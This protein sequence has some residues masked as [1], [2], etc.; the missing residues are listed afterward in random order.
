MNEIRDKIWYFLV[1]SKTNEVFSNLV[2]KK[3]QKLDLITNI[4]LVFTTSSSI[5][6]WTFWKELPILWA[7]IIGLS[8]LMTIVKPYFLF[9]KYIKTFNEK[10]IQWQ[11]LSLS[12]EEL[13]FQ[14]NKNRIG[15][16]NATERFFELKR[17]TL[18]FDNTPDDIVFFNH[19]NLLTKAENQCNNFTS[20]I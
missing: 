8:Q 6:A 10:S 19:F 16:E 14:F 5:A 11:H 13:W 20:K 15:E 4:F 18:S 3:Y 9:P 17:Q 12:L 2:V 1:D 7:L